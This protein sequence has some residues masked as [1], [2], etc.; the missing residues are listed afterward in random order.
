VH[1]PNPNATVVGE[2]VDY[3]VFTALNPEMVMK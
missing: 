3:I 2:V 1:D